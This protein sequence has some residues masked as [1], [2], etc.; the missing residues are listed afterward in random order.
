[1]SLESYL[2]KH[3]ARST[4]GLYAYEIGRYLARA[5]GEEQARRATYADLVR[6]LATLRERYPDRPG[7]VER[8]LAAIKCYYRYL[9]RTG[10]RA[11]YPGSGL[12]LRD[13]RRS[14]GGSAGAAQHQLQDLLTAEELQLLL[15]PRLERY[16][17]LGQRNAVVLGLLVHQALTVREVGWLRTGDVDLAAARLRVSSGGRGRRAGQL[18]TLELVASQVMQLYDYLREGREQLLNG[19]PPTDHLILTSRGTPE[20]GEGIHYLVE[21]LRPLITQKRLTPTLIRQSVV[22]LKLREGQDLR[23]VQLFAG[24]R[25]ISTTEGYRETDLAELRRA[26]E[27]FHPLGDDPPPGNE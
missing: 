19:G 12:V 17:V 8:V 23:K 15:Q 18:R 1:V 5:G 2:A 27:R 13:K 4:A 7:T 25:K 6:E 14:R 9:Y 22:A 3:Y 16:A 10:R 20:R 24:H 11:D 26:V 21:T